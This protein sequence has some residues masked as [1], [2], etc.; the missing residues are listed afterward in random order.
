MT[1]AVPISKDYVFTAYS[2]T[3]PDGRDEVCAV[4]AWISGIG[5]K[6]TL[7]GV[8]INDF[9]CPVERNEIGCKRCRNSRYFRLLR[10]ITNQT[11]IENS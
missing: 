2:T 4:H 11:Q 5:L 6:T 3:D 1:T 9:G 10:L 8:P 7:C